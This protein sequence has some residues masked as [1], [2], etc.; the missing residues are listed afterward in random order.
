MTRLLAAAWLALAP[1]VAGAS[2]VTA[3]KGAGPV[4]GK[5]HAGGPCACGMDCGSACCCA[6]KSH[7]AET[8][9]PDGAAPAPPAGPCLSAAP[10]GGVPTLPSSTSV[11][12]PTADPAAVAAPTLPRPGSADPRLAAPP[13]GLTPA[14]APAPPDDPPEPAAR[15]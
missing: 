11:S 10:C 12:P 7:K 4:A 15:G 5:A 9:P 8:P 3:P 14:F 13:E 6:P 2:A 1:G